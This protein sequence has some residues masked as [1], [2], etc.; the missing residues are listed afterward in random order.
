MREIIPALQ[1]SSVQSFRDTELSA[2]QR[3]ILPGRQD[4]PILCFRFEVRGDNLV[5]LHTDKFGVVLSEFEIV[6]PNEY[7]LKAEYSF[8]TSSSMG[9]PHRVRRLLTIPQRPASQRGKFDLFRSLLSRQR[10]SEC[11]VPLVFTGAEQVSVRLPE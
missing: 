6:G 11:T 8:E 7:E 4:L 1:G 10:E 3:I 5:F 2:G 9:L